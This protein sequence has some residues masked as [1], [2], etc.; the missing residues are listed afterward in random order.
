MVRYLLCTLAAVV[1]MSGMMLPQAIVADENTPVF[2]LV[3]HAEKTDTGPD[4]QLSA[5]GQERANVLAGLLH[6]AG[7]TGI[8]STDFIR[9]RETA[10]PLARQLQIETRL[11]DPSSLV[12]FASNLKRQ[13][14]RYL[15]IGHSNTTT[16]LV[17]MLGG[18]AGQDIDEPA[19]YDRLY[20]LTLDKDGVVETVLLR[21]G[22][23][24]TP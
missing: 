20:V 7:I 3:R 9:T 2:F 4:P 22:K 21:Y 1:I 17:E 5:A 11:Y 24:F 12:E 16:E 8:Y 10:A 15:V 14:G 19:E 13:P 23:R 18:E 6:E